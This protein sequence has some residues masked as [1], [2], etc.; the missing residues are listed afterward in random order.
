MARIH[1][2]NGSLQ[3]LTSVIQGLSV[4]PPSRFVSASF[5]LDSDNAP[6]WYDLLEAISKQKH[7]AGV[8]GIRLAGCG[9]GDAAIQSFA[10][11]I[12]TNTCLEAVE[13][14]G[15]GSLSA[16]ACDAMGP[17]SFC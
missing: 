3:H 7:G 1:G 16:S 17:N 2:M 8:Q 9:L 13:L 4:A 11:A 5:Q 12:S 10:A 15:E 14:Q 6:A